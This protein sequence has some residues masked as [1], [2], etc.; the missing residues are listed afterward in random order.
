V[1]QVIVT[2]NT[3]M[4]RQSAQLAYFTEGNTPAGIMSAGTGWGPDAVRVMQDAWDARMEGNIPGKSKVQWVPEGTKYQPFKESPLKDEFD[5]WLY[6]IVC[7][8]FS[9]PPTAFVKQ[10]NRATAGQADDSGKEDGIESRKLWWKRIAD[11]VIQEDFGYTDLEWGWNEDVEVDP[12]KQAQIDDFNLKNG[13]ALLDEVRDAR[14]LNA[15]P[16]GVGQHA[17]VYTATGPVLLSQVIEDALNPPEPAPI[18]PHLLA[19]GHAQHPTAPVDPKSP[20]ATAAPTKPKAEGGNK[21]PKAEAEKFAKAAEASGKERPAV[22]RAETRLRKQL[23]TIL[24]S[25]GDEVATTAEDQLTQ[26]GKA[27]D[28]GSFAALADKISQDIDLTALGDVK[29]SEI[30]G[31]VM[32]EAAAGFVEDMDDSER[33]K[34]TGEVDE[35]AVEVARQRAAELVSVSGPQSVVRSTREMIRNTIADGLEQNIG[36]KAIADKLQA[37]FA[38]SP[39]RAALIAKTEIRSANTVGGLLAGRAAKSKHGF[40]VKKSWLPASTGC[41]DICEGNAAAGWIDIDR[42]F[43]SGADG[44]PGHPNCSCDTALH[45]DAPKAS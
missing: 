43:P 19:P 26:V 21:A 36:S 30:L 42:P 22:R 17:M 15:L 9:L 33:E 3:V 14:G 12:L 27:A 10:M 16:D 11:D 40:D 24:H 25:L 29:W 8:A 28:D 7:F 31:A 38:F 18:P 37:A 4:R 39:D 6:R 23:V 5:E 20:Q 1:E 41:C 34:L 2:I 35:D 32:Q 45:A 44:T 13:S